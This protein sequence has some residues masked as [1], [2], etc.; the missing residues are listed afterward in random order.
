LLFDTRDAIFVS[1]NKHLSVAFPAYKSADVYV[2]LR[3]HLSFG[4][5]S[6][7]SMALKLHVSTVARLRFPQMGVGVQTQPCCSGPGS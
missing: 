2:L 1:T 5:L 6:A 3:T 7:Q 4:L